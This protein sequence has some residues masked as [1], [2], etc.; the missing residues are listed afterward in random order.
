MPNVKYTF[1]FWILEDFWFF[2][3]E[4]AYLHWD[5]M[6]SHSQGICQMNEYSIY[7]KHR[8]DKNVQLNIDSGP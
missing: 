1:I 3:F 8:W 4:S 6:M 5:F 7:Y 2:I